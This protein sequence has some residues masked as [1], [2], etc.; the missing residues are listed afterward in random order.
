MSLNIKNDE[1]DRLAREL[2]ALTGKSVTVAVTEAVRERLE[3]EH[4]ARRREGLAARLLAIG[5]D[6]ASRL[7]EPYR[8][9]DHDAL[10][11]DERGLPK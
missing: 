9:I 1:A 4:R 5:A 8:S 10:L 7:K 2:A 6:C 3:R 11:Y